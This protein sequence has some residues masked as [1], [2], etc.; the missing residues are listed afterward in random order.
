MKRFIKLAP[1]FFFIGL[2]AFWVTENYFTTGIINYIALLV[3]WLI[4]LQIIYKNRLLGIT[5]GAILGAFSVY[6]SIFHISGYDNHGEAANPIQFISMGS[7]MF[8]T[9]IVM[10]LLMIYNYATSKVGYNESVFTV[11]Y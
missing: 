5:Y 10:A 8:G 6:M 1:E 11:T 4:F 2:G 3:T 9:G 7:I